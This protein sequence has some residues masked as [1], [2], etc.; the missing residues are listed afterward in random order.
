MALA[1]EHVAPLAVE[2]DVEHEEVDVFLRQRRARGGERV[3]L[4]HLV[5][6]ELEVDPAKQADRRLVVDDEDSGRRM[7]LATPHLGAESNCGRR[8]APYPRSGSRRF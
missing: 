5:P 8:V 2:V 6:V 3:S 7:T 1:H 4:E